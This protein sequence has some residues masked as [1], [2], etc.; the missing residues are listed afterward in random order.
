MNDFPSWLTMTLASIVPALAILGF[1]MSL[2][3]RL[4]KAEIL[5]EDSHKDALAAHDRLT[6]LTSSFA[7]YQTQ[8]AKDYIHRETII[9]VEDRL[10]KAIDRLGDRFDRL[11]ERQKNG[12]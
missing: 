8:I 7:V 11:F 3:S 5:A 12:D 1:W 2:S 6:A 10:T 9:A 4:T